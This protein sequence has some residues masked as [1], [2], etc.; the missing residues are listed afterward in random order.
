MNNRIGAALGSGIGW[1]LIH[2]NLRCARLL[3]GR[4]KKVST[5]AQLRQKHAFLRGAERCVM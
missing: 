5:A 2:L 3:R 1:V 4:S